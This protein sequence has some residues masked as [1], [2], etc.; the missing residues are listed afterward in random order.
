MDDRIPT[1]IFVNSG[2]GYEV[3]IRS[4]VDSINHILKRLFDAVDGSPLVDRS[5]EC[6]D[7][8]KRIKHEIERPE[9]IDII[10]GEIL[11]YLPEF[12]VSTNYYFIPEMID[13]SILL[14]Y[15]VLKQ[16]ARLNG[17]MS[18]GVKRSILA[19]YNCLMYLSN[20]MVVGM[21]DYPTT[22]K[23]VFQDELFLDSVK[24]LEREIKSLFC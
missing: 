2:N 19:C 6:R 7:K 3:C 20:R 9:I 16:K 13:K 21:V 11:E 14:F 22:I 24:V 10:E 12:S 18:P 15:T 5:K 4:V 8:L 23:S 17:R 1:D